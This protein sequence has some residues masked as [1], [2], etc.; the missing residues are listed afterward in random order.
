MRAAATQAGMTMPKKKKS[1]EDILRYRANA[2]AR[3]V[4][5]LERAG[6][7]VSRL[8]VRRVRDE[9]LTRVSKLSAQLDV[10]YARRPHDVY[11]TQTRELARSLAGRL[12]KIAP[13]RE[14]RRDVERL[15]EAVRALE[16]VAQ[17]AGSVQIHSRDDVMNRALRLARAL[18]S[19]QRRVPTDPHLADLANAV[20]S[21]VI[22]LR[23]IVTVDSEPT[24]IQHDYEAGSNAK[25]SPRLLPQQT[26]GPR[27]AWYYDDPVNSK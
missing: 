23:A 18:N 10:E 26:F 4:T 22:R 21:L 25:K 17:R 11:G 5:K 1:P 2:L 20:A 12:R 13:R 3:E 7:L 8:E 15:L 9:L 16:D 14:D 6:S 24:I 19:E 27:S